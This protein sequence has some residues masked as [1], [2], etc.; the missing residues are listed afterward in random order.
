M[1]RMLTVHGVG[2]PASHKKPH[3]TG[4]NDCRIYRVCLLQPREIAKA[5]CSHAFSV[6]SIALRCIQ[7]RDFLNIIPATWHDALA[8][9]AVA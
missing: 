1:A 3:L 8:L 2:K 7:E 6:M 9:V 5:T 4:E